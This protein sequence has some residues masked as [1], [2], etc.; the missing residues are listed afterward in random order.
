MFFCSYFQLRSS[1]YDDHEGDGGLPYLYIDENPR[2][3]SEN[4]DYV[5]STTTYGLEMENACSFGH[6]L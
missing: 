2:E 6:H 4:N 5:N 3:P 1:K